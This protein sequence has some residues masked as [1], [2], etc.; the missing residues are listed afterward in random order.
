VNVAVTV[1]LW[2]IVTV[3]VPV[4]LQPPPP[5]QPAKLEPEAGVAV[6]VTWVLRLKTAAQVVPLQLRPAGLDVT[7]PPPVPAFVTVRTAAPSPLSAT[8]SERQ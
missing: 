8:I 1:L 3:Q 6:R 4:P 5:L 7:V 2:S